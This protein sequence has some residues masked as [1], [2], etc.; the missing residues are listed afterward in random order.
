MEDHTMENRQP[1]ALRVWAVPEEEGHDA[2]PSFDRA[3][4]KVTAQALELVEFQPGELRASIQVFLEEFSSLPSEPK[5]GFQVEEIEL[6]LTVN[7]KGGIALLGKLEVGG[8]AGIK[9][10]IRR[11]GTS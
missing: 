1:K 5:T 10:K 8:E 3:K 6:A 11:G 4:G 7:A 2:L 9:V